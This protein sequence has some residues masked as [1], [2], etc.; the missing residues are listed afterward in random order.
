[1]SGKFELSVQ[2]VKRNFRRSESGDF[3]DCSSDSVNEVVNL[4]IFYVTL[5][6]SDRDHRADLSPCPYPA[7]D[8]RPCLAYRDVRRDVLDYGSD[9]VYETQKTACRNCGLHNDVF[10]LFV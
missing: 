8:R 5:F 2:L 4:C 10:V 7:R 6:Y 9:L 3:T 1:M